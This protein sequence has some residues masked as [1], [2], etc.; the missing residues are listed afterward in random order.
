VQHKEI[1]KGEGELVK[2]VKLAAPKRDPFKANWYVYCIQCPII[3]AQEMDRE[4]LPK[5]ET[6]PK[7][8]FFSSF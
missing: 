1:E 6:F 3:S 7:G 4:A 8:N 2:R 5:K